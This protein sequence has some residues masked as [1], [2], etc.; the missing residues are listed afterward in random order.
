MCSLSNLHETTIREEWQKLI[1]GPLRQW[2]RDP[3]QLED[4]DVQAPSSDTIRQAIQLAERLR[5][6]GVP[7]PTR[8]VPDAHGGIVIERE[9]GR[10]FESYRISADGS[11]ESREFED[12]RL[13][14]R[15]PLS[16]TDS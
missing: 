5:D 15:M 13:V 16:L 4:D 2:Q 14:K 12:C 6:Q 11:V 10:L 8:V 7:P 3:S 1:D 9:A